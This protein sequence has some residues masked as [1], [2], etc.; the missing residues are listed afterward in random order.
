[1]RGNQVCIGMLVL[2]MTGALN[3]CITE[4]PFSSKSN[5]QVIGVQDRGFYS[6][7]ANC[8]YIDVKVT[9]LG[10]DG[11]AD[12]YAELKHDMNTCEQK[13]NVYLERGK[14]WVVTFYFYNVS[15]QSEYTYRT[16]I[17]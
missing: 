14:T 8:V 17:L 5:I 13:R 4:N 12:V 9:N 11:T 1:M 16:W 15:Y 6:S 7:K 10:D 3:G 2:L